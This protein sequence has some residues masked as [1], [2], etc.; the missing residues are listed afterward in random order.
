MRPL[1]GTRDVRVI[2][3]DRY[4]RDDMGRLGNS[5]ETLGSAVGFHGTVLLSRPGARDDQATWRVARR[6]F[7]IQMLVRLPREL[8]RVRLSSH[9]ARDRGRDVL[10]IEA[11]AP[12]AFRAT[13]LADA[14]TCVPIALQYQL[15]PA[16]S[17]IDMSAYREFGGIRFATVLRTSTNGQPVQEERVSRVQ[18][19]PPEIEM[20]FRNSR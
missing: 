11:S 12:D 4:R 16:A 3:P 19:N 5:Q 20:A 6:D 18:V 9:A 2:F 8:P 1:A 13:L 15:G 7:V 14:R 17:R 10:A